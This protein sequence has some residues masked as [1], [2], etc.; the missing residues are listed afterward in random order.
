MHVRGALRTLQELMTQGNWVRDRVLSILARAI[1]EEEAGEELIS[2][3]DE[4]RD[5]KKR[6][7][8]P[9]VQR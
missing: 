4:T 6:L 1:N 9:G 2:I 7:N 5:P 8:T 3:I